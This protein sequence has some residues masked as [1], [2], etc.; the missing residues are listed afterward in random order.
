M[1]NFRASEQFSDRI[2]KPWVWTDFLYYLT[3][4]GRKYKENVATMLQFTSTVSIFNL[5]TF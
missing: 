5:Q 3:P 1:I 2:M 4:D